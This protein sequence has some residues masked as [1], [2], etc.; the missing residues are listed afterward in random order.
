[1]AREDIEGRGKNVRV[2]AS[3]VVSLLS[4]GRIPRN[5]ELGLFLCLRLKKGSRRNRGGGEGKKTDLGGL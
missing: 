2:V 5:L 1:M 4:A 3:A